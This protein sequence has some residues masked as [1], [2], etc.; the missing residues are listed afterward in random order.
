MADA[1]AAAGDAGHRRPA[2][3]RG[4][5]P[6]RCGLPEEDLVLRHNLILSFGRMSR[7]RIRE[8]EIPLWAR[9]R[10]LRYLANE[11]LSDEF[12]YRLTQVVHGY[13]GRCDEDAARR[14][15]EWMRAKDLDRYHRPTGLVLLLLNDLVGARKQVRQN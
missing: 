9:N 12:R 4:A 13:I 15:V 14:S 11:K 1:R 3:R 5:S 8:L 6:D 10:A 7:R 2:C